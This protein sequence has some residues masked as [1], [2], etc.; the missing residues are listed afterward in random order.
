MATILFQS[1]L[2]N[3]KYLLYPFLHLLNNVLDARE[4]MMKYLEFVY[5]RK[6]SHLYDYKHLN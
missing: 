3:S 1:I 4:I 6:F 2:P 5:E